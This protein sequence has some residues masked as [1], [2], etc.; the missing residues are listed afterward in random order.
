MFNLSPVPA[1]AQF[2]SAEAAILRQIADLADPGA[3]SVLGW[4]DTDNAYAFFI[5]GS[6]LDYDHAT[7]TLSVAGV[8]V[9]DVTG[10]ASS[11]DDALATFDGTT[12]KIIQN[13]AVQLTA[14]VLSPVVSDAVALGSSLLMW[15]DLFLASGAIIDWNNGDLTLTHTANTL[16]L[17][18]GNL[19]LG[20]NN[21]TLTGSIASTGSRVTKGWFTDLEVTNAIVGS[22]TGNAATATTATTSTLASTLTVAN[23]ASDTTSFIAFWT[24]SSGSLGGSTNANMTFN[25]STGV[26]TFAS[27]V[28]TTTDING[29]TIDGTVIGGSSAAAATITTLIITSFGANWTNAGRT[30]ADLG[31]VTTVD[32]NGGTVDGTIIGGASAAAGTFTTHT[33]NN[34]LAASNDVGA[35][36]ASGTAWADL[37]L[38]SGAVIN[39]NAGDVLITHS[40]NTLTFTGASSGYLYDAMNGPTSNDGAALGTATV[41]WSD[42]FL[43]SG[44][45][46]NFANGN[47]TI[48][49]SSGLLTF[50]SAVTMSAGTVT[51]GTLAGVI[52]AGGATSFEIPNSAAPSLTVNGQ[53]AIDTTVTDFTPPLLK[54]YAGEEVGVVA[55][56]IAQFSS[57]TDGAVPVYSAADDEFKLQVPAANLA[58][59][60]TPNSDQTANGLTTNSLNA[61]LNAFSE[62]IQI[63]EPLYWGSDSKWH[64]TNASGASTSTGFLSMALAAGTDGNA[65]N[66]ALPGSF[67]RN[68]AWAWTVGSP[69]YL[70]VTAQSPRYVTRNST[71]SGGDVTSLALGISGNLSGDLLVAVW[72]TQ[73]SVTWGTP[74]GAGTWTQV[75]TSRNG[76]SVWYKLSDGTETSVTSSSGVTG[77]TIGTVAVFRGVHQTTPVVGTGSAASTTVSTITPT[78]ANQLWVLVGGISTNSG[79][80]SGYAMVTSNPSWTEAYE[81]DAVGQTSEAMAYS[82]IRAVTTATGNITVTGGNASFALALAP[83]LSPATLTQ[84]APA[85]STN[86]VRKVGYAVSADIMYFDPAWTWTVV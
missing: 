12:G 84:T 24:N 35:I 37:F 1:G 40:A 17:A 10:P 71:Q 44:A 83:G 2:T 23:E 57:P 15:A 43:A 19:A 53:I 5:V 9:G 14:T 85:V 36:G 3:N 33:S 6:G 27:T 20:A 48:T 54:Y 50:S 45:L 76:T 16:T 7:H 38:A 49:H 59:D 11:T 29:G 21:L 55:M 73:N 72:Q 56:P 28:L 63:M 31:I 25:A 51:L 52:D 58:V 80:F 69:I 79:D 32:I 13:S 65:I 70:E 86:I 46:L 81:N 74:T 34:L 62:N 42:L 18:G 41:S 60:A 61:G 26:A 22:I 66:V 8:G 78:A 75:G 77:K 64:P 82:S 68:D 39:F 47:Y 30:V 4:D 67:V